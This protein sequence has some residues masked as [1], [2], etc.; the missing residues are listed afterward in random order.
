LKNNQFEFE[1]VLE[2]YG[3]ALWRLTLMYEQE[4][5]RRKDLYQE[6]LVAIWKALPNFEQR[7]SIKTYVF[8]IA[9]NRGITFKNRTVRTDIYKSLNFE[10]ESEN[11]GP[12]ERLIKNEELKNLTNAI[13]K[14]SLPL[15]QVIILHIWNRLSLNIGGIYSHKRYL[16]L[17]F[18]H[19]IKKKRTA[20][21]VFILTVLNLPFYMVLFLAGHISAVILISATGILIIYTVWSVWY[22]QTACSSIEHYREKLRKITD[23]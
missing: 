20:I 8:R 23:Q 22:Y 16:E 21:F 9:Q 11:V 2:T 4:Y 13:S 14:L 15:R 6:I 3:D 12:E 10:T 19:S 7:S 5:N 1:Q 17:L 18:D